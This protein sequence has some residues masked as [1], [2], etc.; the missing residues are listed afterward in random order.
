MKKKPLSI[1]ITVLQLAAVPLLIWLSCFMRAYAFVHTQGYAHAM[2]RA[3]LYMKGDLVY[4]RN[5]ITLVVIL[6]LLILWLKSS[7]KR[8]RRYYG[9]IVFLSLF[10]HFLPELFYTSYPYSEISLT[11]RIVPWA[12]WAIIMSFLFWREFRR[13]G[14]KEPQEQPADLAATPMKRT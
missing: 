5:F 14:R 9:V 2:H 11:R 7:G 8:R 12:L 10:F 1:A 6:S 13:K 3:M 4:P